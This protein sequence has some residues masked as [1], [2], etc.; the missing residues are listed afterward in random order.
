[1]TDS[2]DILEKVNGSKRGRSDL[3]ISYRFSVRA[4]FNLLPSCVYRKIITDF[5]T[6][7]SLAPVDLLATSM[8]MYATE[9]KRK[10]CKTSLWRV[11]EI[12][13]LHLDR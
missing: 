13:L 11:K 2:G 3:G 10:L 8:E 12:K 7:E 6:H 4:T 1:M 5:H 9:S